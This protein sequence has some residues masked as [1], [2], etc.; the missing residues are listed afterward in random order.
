MNKYLF[1]NGLDGSAA[2][3]QKGASFIIGR[4]KSI[5]LGKENFDGSINAD[6]NTPADI[7]KI[8]YEIMY[9][10]MNISK[11]EASSQPAY[12]IFSAIKQLPLI[13]EIVLIMVGPDSNLNDS[14]NSQG[15]Y[16]FPPYALWN[17]S[18][19]NAFPD[20]EE[21]KEYL[22]EYYTLPGYSGDNQKALPKLPTGM[23]FIEN[24]AIRQLRLF[25]GDTVIEGRFGQSI[26]FGSSVAISTKLNS[27]STGSAGSPITIIRNGQSSN[28]NKDVFS[29]TVENLNDD[30]STIWLTSNQELHIDNIEKFPL[31]SFNRG[32]L[33]ASERVSYSSK[34]SNAT[35]Y[36]MSVN[37]QDADSNI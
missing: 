16:Y 19:H 7:G 3:K 36:S 28:L 2:G 17:S 12:P 34:T 6:Y 27:W 9:S 25:E 30:N 24:E 4:V 32:R 8:R 29:T 26:R 10:N 20:L 5:V 21:Y 23:T 1:S 18:N 37:K 15:Y 11:A 31:R 14:I 13:S 22:K 33:I 35:K